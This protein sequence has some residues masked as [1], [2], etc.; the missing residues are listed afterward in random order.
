[1]LDFNLEES[2]MRYAWLAGLFAIAFP[3]LAVAG[4]REELAAE[5]WVVLEKGA[6]SGDMMVRA[7]A[8][9]GL[10]RVPG[11]D[12]E[13]APYVR[14]ALDD[15]Q[16]VV[17][18]AAIKVLADK[19][20]PNAVNLAKEALRDPNL[21]LAKDTFELLSAFGSKKADS[22]LLSVILDQSCPTRSALMEATFAQGTDTIAG[23]FEAG[24]AR[25][26]EFFEKGLVQVR[27]EHRS[28]LVR[29]LLGSRK[30]AVVSA[31]LRFVR[32]SGIDVEKRTLSLLLR[33]RDNEVKFTA[34]ELLAAQGDSSA[35]KVLLPLLDGDNNDKLRFLKAAAA[36]PSE[37]LVPRLKRLM[38]PKTPT[39]LLV[40]VYRAFA[41]SNDIQVRKRVEEDLVATVISRRAAATRA[42]G[43]LLGNRALPRLYKLLNDG[44]PKIR[45]LAAE[46]IGEL[47]QADSVM[48][49]ERALRDTE[50]DVRLAVVQALSQIHDK[51]VIGVASFVVYDTDPEIR[52][53]AILAV[54]NVNHDDALPI[55]RIHVDDPDHEIRFNVIRAMIY[56]NPDMAM[57]Y[58]DR[59]L[60]GLD[61][62]DLV[63]LTETFGA[64][65]LPFLK[66]A[67]QSARAW[68][69][70]AALR[71]AIL[72]PSREKDFLKEVGATNPHADTRRQAL[73]RYRTVS[74]VDALDMA[75]ALLKDSDP[76]VRM[77]AIETLVECGDDSTRVQVQDGLF[78][79]EE[80]V[81]VTA[82]MGLLEYPKSRSGRGGRR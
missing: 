31:T 22:M 15:H 24:L 14:D 20:A 42:I 63:A 41:G 6:R 66:K 77:T 73:Q 3:G 4:E 50:R 82:A 58:F 23:V 54:C 8:V 36:A 60:A 81:R 44:S 48:I 5:A 57:S 79:Q 52:K 46:A 37:A 13:A 78:D 68:A 64:G 35:V 61:G 30:P 7:R 67:V 69:R 75:E 16:W 28:E 70:S 39:E 21:P 26:D 47:G 59:S 10:V 2:D 55:L 56:L 45:R 9:Q 25:G 17:R 53:T 27:R 74:C 40:Q 49:L 43:R 19:G 12:K 72:L 38:D 11:K 18:K 80:I 29:R 71:G 33:S 62:D 34:A 51:S 65:A 32:D 76:E 1:L